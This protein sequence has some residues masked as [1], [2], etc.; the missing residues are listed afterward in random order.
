MTSTLEFTEGHLCKAGEA[1]WNPSLRKRYITISFRFPG[2]KEDLIGIRN[3]RGW[4]TAGRKGV[5][6]GSVRK[7]HMSPSE[8]QDE[9]G[10]GGVI[11]SVPRTVATPGDPSL[12]GA[13]W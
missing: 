10:P 6:S 5:G 9:L 12:H 1:P 4:G 13:G 8:A 7:R 3:G 2:I 11:T